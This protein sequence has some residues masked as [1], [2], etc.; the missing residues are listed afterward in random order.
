M[1]QWL[2]TKNYK[3]RPNTFGQPW[4]DYQAFNRLI[5][6]LDECGSGK[7]GKQWQYLFIYEV[8]VRVASSYQWFNQPFERATKCPFLCCVLPYCSFF[9]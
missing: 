1:G 6:G 4:P 3:N 8:V 9:C 5:A 2:T 7:N